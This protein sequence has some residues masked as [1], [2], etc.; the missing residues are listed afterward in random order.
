MRLSAFTPLVL[1][2]GLA[3][4]AL[5]GPAAAAPATV[6]VG[7]GGDK[8]VTDNVTVNAG[9]SVTWHWVSGT[10]NVHFTGGAPTGG[11]IDFQNSSGGDKTRTI[12]KACTYTDHS[13]D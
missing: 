5:A 9:E 12:F 1:T 4:L 10:H 13:E 11:D 6:Q 8:F 2:A 7:K 3:T